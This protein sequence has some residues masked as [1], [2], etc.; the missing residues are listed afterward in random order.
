MKLSVMVLLSSALISCGP[1]RTPGPHDGSTPRRADVQSALQQSPAGQATAAWLDAYN[2]GRTDSLEAVIA[3][4]YPPASLERRSAALRATAFRLWW[5]NYGRLTPVRVDS[6]TDVAA[7]VSVRAELTEGWGTLYLDVDSIVPHA[8]TG[9]G[10]IPFREPIDWRELPV[11][12]D[13]D[14][15]AEVERLAQQLVQADAFSGVV[16]LTRDGKPLLR[17][18]FGLADR[19]AQ[20]VN[21]MDTPFELASVGKMF[22]AVAVAKL[23]EQGKLSL[24]AT[25]GSLLSDYPTGQSGSHV[26]VHHL[27]TM[28]S[29]IP[30]LF[31]SPRYWAGRAGIRTLSDYWPF[32][33]TA[34]LEFPPG[35]QWA[36]S[37][38]NFLI[39]GS[40]V[41]RVT[42]VPFAAAV[43][44]L[45]FRPSGMTRT[46]YRS[47]AMAERARGYTHMPPGSAPGAVPD[48]DRWH[49]ATQEPE[50]QSDSATG[51]PAG[52][53][54]STADDLARFAEALLRGQLL[55]EEMTTKVMTGYLPTE[56]DGRHGYGLETRIWNGVRIVGHGGGFTGVSNQ[57]DFYPDLGYVLVVLGNSDASGTEAIANRVRTL[58]AASRPRSD[59]R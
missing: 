15:V 20:R 1:P 17:R 48:P 23:A 12:T 36:Y 40:V 41:E 28:S 8:I 54:V 46:S 6:L 39:L 24:D 19:K 56:Y 31:R 21:T 49:P 51:S 7:V 11:A 33:A 35:T 44:Q 32:F 37:N 3:R 29:G 13:A 47:G 9:I 58:I 5:R 4:L 42:G 27:L 55:S 57:V 38:S 26:T 16:L 25:I 18:A 52:G 14:L 50:P 2:S 45:V 22:T 43:E 53:G 30:D 10:M 59:V 34:A